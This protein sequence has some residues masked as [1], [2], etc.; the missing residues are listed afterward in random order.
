MKNNIFGQTLKLKTYFKS[1]IYFQIILFII[2]NLELILSELEDQSKNKNKTSSNTQKNNKQI[3]D[4]DLINDILVNDF[5]NQDLNDSF[6]DDI[7]YDDKFQEQMAINAVDQQII[8]ELYPNPDSMSYEQL[9]QLE[10]N[11]G[12]VNKGLSKKQFDKLPFVKYDKDKYSK[13]YQCIICMEEFEKNEKVTL[14]P[15]D[16]IFHSNCIE[17]W[18]LKQRSCPFCKSE[19][20]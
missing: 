19:I 2:K 16:H 1:N 15:C 12:N 4:I 14:L 7:L 8:D 18:L 10:D 11:M 20:G 3:N 6:E 13:N 9:L 17:Q 5:E